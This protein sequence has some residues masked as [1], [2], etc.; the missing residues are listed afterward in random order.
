MITQAEKLAII[1]EF[2]AN[3]IDSGSTVVQIAILTKK[4][5]SLQ[6]HLKDHK[7]DF[8]SQ[9]G[10][11]QMVHDRKGLLLYLQRKSTS[12]QYKDVITRLGIRK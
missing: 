3:E 7:K 2:G 8:S 12:E 6:Q 4:I 11:M 9:R 5:E 1:K 10:L